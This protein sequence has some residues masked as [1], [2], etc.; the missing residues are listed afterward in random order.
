VTRLEQHGHAD[1]EFLMPA[2]GS[3]KAALALPHKCLHAFFDI[4]D[5]KHFAVELQRY[6]MRN[7]KL[8][9]DLQVAGRGCH[10]LSP[11]FLC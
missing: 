1:L 5:R 7:Y 4:E 11:L 9:S 8:I 3:L 10:E 2:R 6:R